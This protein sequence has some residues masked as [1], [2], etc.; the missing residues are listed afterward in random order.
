LRV[1][2]QPRV[3]G[4][5]PAG[6]TLGEQLNMIILSTKIGTISGAR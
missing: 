6:A 4:P 3:S 5:D 1:G 2:S